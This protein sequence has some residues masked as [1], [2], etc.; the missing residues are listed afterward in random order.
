LVLASNANATASIAPHTIAA[1]VEGNVTVQRYFPAV[2]FDLTA[3]KKQWRF[4]GFPYSNPQLIG[5]ITG[6]NSS[7]VTPT[8]MEFREFFNFNSTYGNNA[9]RNNGYSVF[10]SNTDALASL[11]G[12]VAWIYDFGTET[13]TTGSLSAAQTMTTVGNLLESGD[14]VTK[15]LNYTN[16]P[17]NVASD[18]GWNLISNPFASTIDWTHASVTKTNIN[19][20]IYRWDPQAGNFTTFNGT[21]GTGNYD[22][23]IESGSSFFVKA[24][25][26]GAS[27]TFGQDAKVVAKAKQPFLG[28][29]DC[30]L[31]N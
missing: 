31:F 20:K 3:R 9:V 21:T 18:K 17:Q 25:G 16:G 8:M 6:I 12:L 10:T 26:V 27:I 30:A 5:N 24:N 7:L 4:L 1:S 15:S 13:A 19:G 22:N 14:P 2:D 23:L 11:D 28:I 29:V